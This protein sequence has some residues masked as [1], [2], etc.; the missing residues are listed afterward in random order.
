MYLAIPNESAPVPIQGDNTPLEGIMGGWISSVGAGIEDWEA[1][2]QAATAEVDST[3]PLAKDDY[4]K[5]PFSVPGGWHPGVTVTQA[6]TESAKYEQD[7]RA[8]QY[9]SA[10]PVLA[11][12]GNLIGEALNPLW[13]YGAG[14]LAGAGPV[15]GKIGGDTLL[16][17]LTEQGIAQG[18]QAG[19]VT[20]A[21]QGARALEGKP[22]DPSD[23]IKN[24]VAGMILG[25]VAH[26]IHLALRPQVAAMQDI[27][28]SLEAGKPLDA[29]NKV[30]PGGAETV[31]MPTAPGAEGI[32]AATAPEFYRENGKTVL[33]HQGF[34]PQY[35][36]MDTTHPVFMASS[37]VAARTHGEG[38]R[39]MN[40]VAANPK[41]VDYKGAVF[42]GNPEEGLQRVSLEAKKAFD[43]G[44][45]ALIAHNVVDTA[46]GEGAPHT[47]YVVKSRDQIHLV[48]TP[49]KPNTMP[50]G[51]SAP[52]MGA[53]EQAA[54]DQQ[55]MAEEIKHGVA[56]AGPQNAPIGET[57]AAEKAAPQFPPGIQESYEADMA[58]SNKMRVMAD[59]LKKALGCRLS[60]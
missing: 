1:P 26:S 56:P 11:G 32:E 44:H 9:A 30:I 2:L 24:F 36:E 42:T 6:F 8:A 21:E 16:G 55:V 27:A 35:P 13:W 60:G 12:A 50:V 28:N 54:K 33:A 41:V 53:A 10:H 59:A 45:D 46:T 5:L 31:V 37:K 19:A 23:I 52:V 47:T 58:D 3:G 4:E 7:Q 34:N 38:G 43:E 14:E 22:T 48:S 25:G 17:K 57:G 18:I 51:G 49:P 29:A 20:A 15:L 39:S 40:F